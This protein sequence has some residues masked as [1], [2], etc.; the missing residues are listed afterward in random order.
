MERIENLPEAADKWRTLGVK[1]QRKKDLQAQGLNVFF[2]EKPLFLKV[3]FGFGTQWSRLGSNQRPL[4]CRGSALPAELRNR[5]LNCVSAYCTF[6][7]I[8]GL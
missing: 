1:I 5:E 2:M 3:F 8:A 4:P 7:I 6:I